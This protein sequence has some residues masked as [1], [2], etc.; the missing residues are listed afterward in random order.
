MGREAGGLTGG[1]LSQRSCARRLRGESE[2]SYTGGGKPS[3]GQPDL[4]EALGASSIQHIL[5]LG[6][7]QLLYPTWVR[8]HKLP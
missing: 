4:T 1:Y 5:A 2:G 8:H 3:R 6:R 7:G